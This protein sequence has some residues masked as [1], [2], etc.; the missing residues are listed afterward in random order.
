M[1]AV[2][3]MAKRY[4]QV[5]IPANSAK[6]LAKYNP[7]QN[8]QGSSTLAITLFEDV[9]RFWKCADSH[10]RVMWPNDQ[11]LSHGHRESKANLRLVAHPK[12]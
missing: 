6:Y 4:S 2:H 11:K 3:K 1:R 10:K 7:R 5:K 12:A 9:E 8:Y